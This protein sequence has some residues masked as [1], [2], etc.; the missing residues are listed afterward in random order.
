MKKLILAAVILGG[1]IASYKILKN[2][3][4]VKK[5]IPHPSVAPED[6]PMMYI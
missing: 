5:I 4:L 1:A 6:Q 3:S 2:R